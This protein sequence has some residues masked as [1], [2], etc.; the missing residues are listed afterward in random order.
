MQGK[1]YSPP[2]MGAILPPLEKNKNTPQDDL[3]VG[4][5]FGGKQ[6]RF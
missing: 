2:L 6:N 4:F 5:V 3:G 1:N